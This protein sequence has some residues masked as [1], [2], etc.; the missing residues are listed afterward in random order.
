VKSCD[1]FC[2]AGVVGFTSS[3]GFFSSGFVSSGLTVGSGIPY[4]EC[5]YGFPVGVAVSSNI[6]I[7]SVNVCYSYCVSFVFSPF[8]ELF[9][10]FCC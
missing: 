9:L 2:S 8:G 5:P 3:S 10:F 1:W 7:A 4:V 6:R